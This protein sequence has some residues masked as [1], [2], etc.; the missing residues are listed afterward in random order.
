MRSSNLS[1][2]SLIL[3]SSAIGLLMSLD[4][5]AA[6]PVYKWKDSSGQSHYSQAP[7]E[8]QKYETINPHD[9]S[10]TSSPASN[11]SPPASTGPAEAATS[12]SSQALRQRNCATARKNLE[13]LTNS[14][15]TSLD[16]S[17]SG[18]PARITP[19]VRAAE[20]ERANQMVTQYCN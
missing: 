16:T 12:P 4:A 3:L 20:I 13:T 5:S 6:D 8:G 15:N 11:G 17:G 10:K 14:A 9:S 19:E 7:P 2:S 18:R 1:L